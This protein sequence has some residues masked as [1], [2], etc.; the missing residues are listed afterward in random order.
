[1]TTTLDAVKSKK[2]DPSAEE[3]AAKELGE[4]ARDQGLSLTSP[5][6]L[7]K[8]FIKTALEAT[9]NEETTK[10]RGHEKRQADP[11]RDSANVRNGPRPED[12]VD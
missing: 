6:R 10:H 7:L 8:Q 4:L 9:L 2:Q 1:M 3:T 5:N 12:G 11:E